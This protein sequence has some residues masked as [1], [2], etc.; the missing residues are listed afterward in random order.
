MHVLLVGAV[1]GHN[2]LCSVPCNKYLSDVIKNDRT[3]NV[4]YRVAIV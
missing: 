3:C 4:M 1:N 2:L